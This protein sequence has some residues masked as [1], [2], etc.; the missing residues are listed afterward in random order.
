[1]TKVKDK[2]LVSFYEEQTDEI[3]FNVLNKITRRRNFSNRIKDML[4]E[5]IRNT[6][7]ETYDEVIN[8]MNNTNNKIT[9]TKKTNK[10]KDKID[11][12]SEGID[13][14]DEN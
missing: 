6:M 9:I 4:I 8:E 7:P 5:H 10:S 1:M 11:I 14:W 3:I 13:N 12:I 2:V